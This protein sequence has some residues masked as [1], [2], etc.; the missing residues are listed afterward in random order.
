M[1][2]DPYLAA[3]L[4]FSWCYC[5]RGKCC[6]PWGIVQRIHQIPQFHRQ[7]STLHQHLGVQRIE[8]KVRLLQPKSQ[9]C[10]ES[11]IA[12]W[13]CSTSCLTVQCRRKQRRIARC[14][15]SLSG[16]VYRHSCLGF[17]TKDRGRCCIARCD[18][19][20]HLLH[21][22]NLSQSRTCRWGSK[23]SVHDARTSYH[24]CRDNR[25]RSCYCWQSGSN[26]WGKVAF[27]KYHRLQLRISYR[28]ASEYTRSCAGRLFACWLC[29]GTLV[30]STCYTRKYT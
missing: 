13:S 17:Q 16:S 21:S 8:L 14:M 3:R 24:P 22:V 28:W 30:S 26:F 29:D 15:C 27:F 10:S 4:P 7:W 20:L 1:Q 11:R 18:G 19:K 9:T 2:T 23:L 6:S 5:Q 12:R 25:I